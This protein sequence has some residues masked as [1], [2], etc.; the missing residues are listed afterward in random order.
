MKPSLNVRHLVL[1]VL[2]AAS[3]VA[4]PAMAQISVNIN[5]VPP[6]PLVEAR[7]VIAPGYTWAPGY[8]TLNGDRHIWVRGR[9]IVQRE[10]YVWSPDRWEQ[11]GTVYVRQPGNWQRDVH[12]KAVKIEKQKKPKHWNNG[13]GKGDDN[14]KHG[15]KGKGKHN[16]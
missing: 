14:G 10:G 3:A 4:L 13:R 16:D 12:Y 11:R 8:W 9:T 1:S 6:A 5:L 15:G 7:P 2:V